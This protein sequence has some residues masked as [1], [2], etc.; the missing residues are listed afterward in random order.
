MIVAN[1]VPG[2]RVKLALFQALGRRP[3]ASGHSGSQTHAR[4]FRKDVEVFVADHVDQH[5]GRVTMGRRSVPILRGEVSRAEKVSP[6]SLVDQ[7][8]A[9]EKDE[10]DAAGRMQVLHV[11]A[12]FHQQG[13]TAGSVV[14]PEEYAARIA[15]IPIGKGTRVVVA[16]DEDP[17]GRFGVPGDDQ[18]RHP[19]GLAADRIG[20]IERLITHLRAEPTEVFGNQRLLF[21][22]PTTAA[23]PWTD[24]T[25]LLQVAVGAS[26]IEP[27]SSR[28]RALDAARD[29]QHH[30]NDQPASARNAACD[31]TSG[32]QRF[33]PEDRAKGTL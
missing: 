23:G 24:P 30:A 28:R 19:H 32:W 9:V 33:P 2:R 6:R 11:V 4:L 18:V 27:R 22:H 1:L 15:P 29:G 16:G 21:G 25:N 10:I 13:D 14:G 3:H 20:R 7:L 12:E 31:G 17:L 8:L 5:A 26:R